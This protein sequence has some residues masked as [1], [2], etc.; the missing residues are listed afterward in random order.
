MIPKIFK[1]Q[2]FILSSFFFLCGNIIFFL[3]FCLFF[4]FFNKLRFYTNFILKLQ[5]KLLLFNLYVCLTVGDVIKSIAYSYLLLF[6]CII[7]KYLRAT[8]QINFVLIVLPSWNKVFIIIITCIRLLFQAQSD[9]GLHCLPRSVW[10]NMFIIRLFFCVAKQKF[11]CGS[12]R[13]SGKMLYCF[14]IFVVKPKS[15]RFQLWKN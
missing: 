6:I 13:K 10:T 12:D 15:F 4:C 5:S 2:I 7:C 8:G 3:F 1:H 9:Q 11:T 14:S